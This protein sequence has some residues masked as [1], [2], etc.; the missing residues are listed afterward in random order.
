MVFDLP[1]EF[2]WNFSQ[3]LSAILVK[4]EEPDVGQRLD[5]QPLEGPSLIL[6]P[7]PQHRGSPW[8]H[9]VSIHERTLHVVRLK[10]MFITITVVYAFV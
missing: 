1:I 6:S 10:A 7:A 2:E 9:T 8:R 4:Q 3:D 5:P